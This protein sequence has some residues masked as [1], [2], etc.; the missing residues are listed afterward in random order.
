M[1][2]FDSTQ[3]EPAAGPAK[4]SSRVTFKDIAAASDNQARETLIAAMVARMTLSEKVDQMTGSTP[5]LGM[6]RRYNSST[7]DSGANAR[8]GIPALKFADGPRGIALNH[9]TCF[10]CSMARG[11]SW[12]PD[13]EERIGDAMGVEARAQ[14]ANFYGGVCI[15]VL[16]HPAWGRAQETY[17]EDPCH[18]GAM[19]AALLRGAQRHVMACVK[20]FAANSIENTRFTVDV[21]MDARTLREV[22]LPHFRKCVEAGAASVMSAYNTLNGAHCGASR[23]LL[24]D[25][26][27]KEWDFDGF[28]MSDFIFGIK[29][30]RAAA[31]GGQ[32]MEMPCSLHF[33]GNLKKLV[34]E[35]EVPGFAIDE[36]VTRILRQKARFAN[37]GEPERYKRSAVACDAHRQLAL[38]AAQKGMV[39]LKNDS[40]T[41]PLNRGFT[42][43]IAVFG[44]LADKANIGDRGSSSVYP[45]DAITPLQ[46][47]KKAAGAGVKVTYDKG[48]KAGGITRLASTCDA[49]VVVVG[50][51]WRDE[52]EGGFPLIP[53]GDRSSLR[54][55][56]DQEKL[57]RAVSETAAR[58]IVILEGGSAFIMEDWIDSAYAVLMAWYPGMMGGL[59]IGRVLFGDAEPG[60]RLPLIIPRSQDQLPDFP[61]KA[62]RVRYNYFHGYKLCDQHGHAPRFAFGHG[63][64]YTTFNYE[65]L[66]VDKKEFR[67]DETITL[68]VDVTNT[69]ARAGS[70]VVQ[71]YIGY[72]GSKVERPVRELKAFARAALEPGETRTLHFAIDPRDLA[73]YNTD[74]K[75][76]H[77]EEI[78]YQVFAG[79]S[80]RFEDLPLR[81]M[82]RIMGE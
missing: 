41:L 62:R 22:Y 56:K 27:K 28:V 19:G 21:R 48:D 47:I 29:N 37:V 60:G 67:P 65:N 66:R 3:N 78:V 34:R 14:G 70:D 24:R 45:P 6:L 57:I 61:N 30:G 52:G 50:C 72:R 69:G 77:I 16:R 36:S 10:P 40:D 64:G 39:L 38:E 7:Y 32:D 18:L 55:D 17:G 59:A 1:D 81:D 63:L 51:T 80:S 82:F 9:S 12:D 33:G 26:L 73:Y 75:R 23:R 44:E 5:L 43:S 35:G 4:G 20:H 74:Q 11:A 25:L 53:G 68:S 8:L 49:A 46:G 2:Q 71:V 58:T 54:L 15:N 13:L 42:A 76:W 79:A 31:L